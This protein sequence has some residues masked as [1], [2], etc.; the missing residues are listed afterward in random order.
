[1]EGGSG[2]E[3]AP[4]APT[5]VAASKKKS[6][7]ELGI[8]LTAR[9]KSS[10][11]G[12][13]LPPSLAV[14][15]CWA[16]GRRSGCQVKVSAPAFGSYRANSSGSIAV[17]PTFRKRTAMPKEC[18]QLLAKQS[19]RAVN[20]YRIKRSKEPSP[21]RILESERCVQWNWIAIFSY[22]AS[23]AVSLAIWTGLFRAVAHLVK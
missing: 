8:E 18:F 19:Q 10:V 21:M 23:L 11:E 7:V 20:C 16:A 15:E 17:S 5:S 12:P 22:T 13:S 3:S 14:P 9:M 4:N 1:M 6:R 2:L